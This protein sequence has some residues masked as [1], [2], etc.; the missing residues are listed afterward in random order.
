MTTTGS[1]RVRP[2]MPPAEPGDTYADSRR[3]GIPKGNGITFPRWLLFPSGAFFTLF[4]LFGPKYQRQLDGVIG[5]SRARGIGFL[6]FGLL[7]T[8]IAGTWSVNARKSSTGVLG[9]LLIAL[10]TLRRALAVCKLDDNVST[11]LKRHF[12]RF[13]REENK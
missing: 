12:G 10:G 8:W 7:L 4:G 13:T 2:D 6:G 11:W 3:R 9:G 1:Y 5:I